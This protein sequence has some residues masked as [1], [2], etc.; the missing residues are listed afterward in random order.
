MKSH[1]LGRYRSL[2]LQQQWEDRIQEVS[3]FLCFFKNSL[4]FP[5]DNPHSQGQ[6]PY[7]SISKTL[8]IQ[9][10]FDFVIMQ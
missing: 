9:L 5:M 7:L 10:L 3:V 8:S 6:K 4:I 1:F 2:A